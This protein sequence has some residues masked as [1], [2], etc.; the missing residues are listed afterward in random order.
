MKTRIVNRKHLVLVLIAILIAF[1][2]QSSYAQT[3]TT[4]LL[5]NAT[6]YESIVI[7]T[8][9]GGT[10]EDRIPKI[11]FT[12][13]GPEGITFLWTVAR[14]SD[15]KVAV[16]LRFKTDINIDDKFTF[17]VQ[18]DAIVDYD[19]P[20]LTAEVPITVKAT[21][22]FDY[23]QGP[24]LWMTAKGRDIDIDYLSEKSKRV[25]TEIQVAQNG[26]NEGDTL[27]ELHWASEPIY[28]TIDCGFWN[29]SSDNVHEVVHRIGLDNNPHVFY[30]AYALINIISTRDQNG[31]WMGV[32]SDDSV[33]VWLNGT[34]IL[35]RKVDRG[36]TGIQNRFCVNL[37][38]GNNLL[39]VKVSNYSGHWG[40]FFR[41]YLDEADFTTA[42]P[43]A[44]TAAGPSTQD[45]PVTNAIVSIS[46][47]EVASPAI[48]EQLTLSLN[49]EGG[50]S[51]AGYQATMQ[52]DDTALRYVSSANGDYLPSGAFFV[53]PVVAGNQVTL[54]SSAIGGVS[55]GDGTLATL[56]FEVIEVKASRNLIGNCPL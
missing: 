45:L 34:V 30:S 41:I 14:G 11:D 9:S 12:V 39:L 13:S 8:L 15:T 36:T 1:G 35:R 4:T 56:T 47:S 49:I 51:V 6:L 20:A 19:G 52:F 54:A 18:P 37:K 46:P 17:T 29:C 23:I 16:V 32:G 42:I 55:N 5:P 48:D 26:V 38:A 43:K 33:K 21:D 3:I 27:G 50:E 44:K 22:T 10:Y 53:P 24:W 40:L 28:P 31:V 25:L 7:L 2:T